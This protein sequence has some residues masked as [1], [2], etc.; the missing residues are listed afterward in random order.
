MVATDELHDVARPPGLMFGQGGAL[1][2]QRLF[3][4]SHAAT[5]SERGETIQGGLNASKRQLRGPIAQLLCDGVLK[6]TEPEA[7]GDSHREQRQWDVTGDDGAGDQAAQGTVVR[8]GRVAVGLAKALQHRPRGM[9]V[10]CGER[11]GVSAEAQRGDEVG[12]VD[13]RQ[14]RDDLRGALAALPGGLL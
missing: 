4:G 9:D 6:F 13:V 2:Q 14:R 8:R 12:Q 3:H 5:I 1:T 10:R 7:R 11:L